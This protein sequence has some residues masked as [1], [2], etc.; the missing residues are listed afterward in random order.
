MIYLFENPDNNASIVYNPKGLTEDDLSNAI[1]VQELPQ[2]EDIVG[3]EAILKCRKS[4]GEVWWEYRDR[5]L[6]T[7]EYKFQEQRILDLEMAIA[8]MMGGM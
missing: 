3:K 2:Q 5:P 8:S 4:T 7:E 6:S 1:I